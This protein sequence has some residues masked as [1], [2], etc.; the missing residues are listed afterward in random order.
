MKDLGIN[1]SLGVRF[2][3]ASFHLGIKDKSEKLTK[4]ILRMKSEARGNKLQA[5]PLEVVGP[6]RSIKRTRKSKLITVLQ[7]STINHFLVKP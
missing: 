5:R 2:S 4:F 1:V 6:E 7:H 3:A